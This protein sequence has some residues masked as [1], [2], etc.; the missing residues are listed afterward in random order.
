MGT[1][2]EKH[3]RQQDHRNRLNAAQAELESKARKRKILSIVG[4]V[5]AVLILIGAV[6]LLTGKS[7]DETASSSTTTA[8]GSASSTTVPGEPSDGAAV[9]PD[10]PAGATLT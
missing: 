10:P 2:A 6:V 5:L 9:L 4:G 7:S 3:A 8:A 1:N